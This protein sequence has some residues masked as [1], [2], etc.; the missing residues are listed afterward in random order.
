VSELPRRCEKRAPDRR[1]K[2][3]GGVEKK[4]KVRE[5]FA[6]GTRAGGRRRIPSDLERFGRKEIVEEGDGGKKNVQ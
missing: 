6:T 5:N 3:P 4:E 2:R 1:S